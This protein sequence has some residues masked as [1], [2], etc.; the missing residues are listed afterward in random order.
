M[1]KVPVLKECPH[2]VELSVAPVIR[3]IPGGD[4]SVSQLGKEPRSDAPTGNQSLKYRKVIHQRFLP[5]QGITKVLKAGVDFDTYLLKGGLGGGPESAHLLNAGGR[6]GGGFLFHPLHQFNEVLCSFLLVLL[7]LAM[8]VVLI[9]PGSRFPAC[10]LNHQAESLVICGEH[11]IQVL[12]VLG[13]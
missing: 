9:M 10:C 5:A 7:A 12:D 4:N 13:L 11:C 2:D 8:P 1:L 3:L 6:R